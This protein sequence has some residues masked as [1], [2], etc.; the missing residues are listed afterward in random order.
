VGGRFRLPQAFLDSIG[1]YIHGVTFSRR[2]IVAALDR[3]V[4]KAI[5]SP[6]EVALEPAFDDP[7]TDRSNAMRRA[8]VELRERERELVAR[9]E[10]ARAGSGRCEKALVDLLATRTGKQITE[11]RQ[12]DRAGTTGT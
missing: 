12:S 8:G 6:I 4:F 1:R 3:C 2:H 9:L 7:S 10:L 5:R 11:P